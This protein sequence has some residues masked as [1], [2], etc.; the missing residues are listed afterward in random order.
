MKEIKKNFQQLSALYPCKLGGMIV[1]IFIPGR[2]T[3]I[4]I[5]VFVSV[6]FDV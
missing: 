5:E 4:V 6:V 2:R 1:E 3:D